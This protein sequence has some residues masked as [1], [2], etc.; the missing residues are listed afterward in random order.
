MIEH[1][2]TLF[3]SKYLPQGLSLLSSMEK[4][5]INFRLWILCIDDEAYQILKELNYEH[6]NP[7]KL[8]DFE[9]EDLLTAKKNRTFTE[10][11]WTLTPFTFDFVYKC[12]NTIKRLTYIDADMYFFND[13]RQIFTNFEKSNKSILITKHNYSPFYDQSNFSGKFCV[14]FLTIDFE[15]GEKVRKDWELKCLDWC[16]NRF[17]NGKF[18]D[19]KYLDRWPIDFKELVYIVDQKD[20]FLAPW[21]AL[22]FSTDEIVA[23]H[24]HGLKILN[25]HKINIGN[26]LIPI[27]TY[28]YIYKEYLD[29]IFD[30]IKILENLNFYNFIQQRSSLILKI[31]SLMSVPYFFIRL[32]KYS[33]IIKK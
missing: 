14:Q 8:S 13:T 1:F 17:E 16:Y 32:F 5:V 28:Q 31:K 11:C 27:S 21:N 15:F 10:Y 24:F 18:G 12:D 30:S 7:L 23:F 6:V 26:Y 2:V 22:Q 20:L 19:Q 29:S 25:N 3:N 4:N 9:T 33:H